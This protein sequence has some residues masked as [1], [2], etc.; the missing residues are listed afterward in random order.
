MGIRRATTRLRRLRTCVLGTSIALA[1]VVLSSCNEGNFK[2]TLRNDSPSPVLLKACNGANCD[3]FNDEARVEPGDSIP[4]TAASSRGITRW[5]LVESDA[6]VRL[7]C[8]PLQF[9][10]VHEGVVLNV[11]SAAPC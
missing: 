8:I 9:E 11:S 4:A 7:G 3:A 5:W 2:V 1:I 6:G 10:G